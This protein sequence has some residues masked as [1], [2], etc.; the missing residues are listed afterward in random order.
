MASDHGE[1]PVWG[2]AVVNRGTG[3]NQKQSAITGGNRAPW[4]HRGA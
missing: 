2:V 3:S 4:E 1:G